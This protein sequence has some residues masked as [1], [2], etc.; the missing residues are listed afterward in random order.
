MKLI[1]LSPA[2]L[3]FL[4]KSLKAMVGKDANMQDKIRA[5]T[6]IYERAQSAK[7]MTKDHTPSRLK[8]R[9]G[10]A[11]RLNQIRNA[12]KPYSDSAKATAIAWLMTA[13][14]TKISSG[15]SGQHSDSPEEIKIK[16]YEAPPQTIYKTEAGIKFSSKFEIDHGE[17][18][19]YMRAANNL[20]GSESRWILTAG[21]DASAESYHNRIYSQTGANRQGWYTGGL[22]KTSP[23]LTSQSSWESWQVP[24]YFGLPSCGMMIHMF[25]YEGLT[26][27]LFDSMFNRL[28]QSALDFQKNFMVDLIT[29]INSRFA[30]HTFWNSNKYTDANIKVYVCKSKLRSLS[31]PWW[32]SMCSWGN[33]GIDPETMYGLI[34]EK[35]KVVKEGNKAPGA[36]VNWFDA[37]SENIRYN[38]SPTTTGRINTVVEVSSVLGMTPQ[39]SQQFKDNWEVLDVLDCTIGPNDCW[40]LHVEEKFS[41]GFSI[42]QWLADFG[43]FS[44]GYQGMYDNRLKNTAKG[45]VVLIPVFSGEPSPSYVMGVANPD[46][47]LSTETIMPI[48]A[49]PCRIRHMVRHGINISWPES[50][51]PPEDYNAAGYAGPTNYVADQGWSVIQERTNFTERE[52]H[53]FSDGS[54]RVMSSETAQTGGPKVADT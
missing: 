33:S 30:V 45:D 44:K 24:A 9:S 6:N 38:N 29:N 48:D 23:T 50:I 1:F 53:A 34:P 20:Y 39:Q 16:V 35:G 19:K 21:A 37:I 31:I 28:N 3:K 7:S 2:Q 52:T 36:G 26:N 15:M 17:P 46:P 42:R 14:H 43:D 51:V 47:L 11:A 10:R 8:S 22:F 25:I 4:P 54:I 41:K 49:A 13:V 27:E 5:F 12:V 32:F 40:D 18:N